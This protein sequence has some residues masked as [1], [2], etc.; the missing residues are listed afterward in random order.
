M[1]PTGEFET[2][3]T[4][5]GTVTHCLKCGLVLEFVKQDEAKPEMEI[6]R[7]V[8]CRKAVGVV[9]VEDAK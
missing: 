3:V 1:K 8:G 6:W 5:S 7:C 4:E 2:R 9:V